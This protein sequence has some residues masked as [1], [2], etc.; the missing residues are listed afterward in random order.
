LVQGFAR[1][2]LLAPFLTS[3]ASEGP[4][5]PEVWWHEEVGGKI[6]KERPPAPGDKDP[7]PNL[8]TVPAKPAPVDAGAWNRMTSALIIDRIAANHAAAMAPIPAPPLAPA[9]MRPVAAQP[10]PASA[11][12]NGASAALTGATPSSAPASPSAAVP[13]PAVKPAASVTA[14]IGPLPPLPT[15]EPPRPAIAPG[16]P[17]PAIPVSAAPPP[18]APR[19]TNELN[20]DFSPN[21]AALTDGALAAIKSL[22]ATHGDRGIA[23]VGYGEAVTSD[24][25]GQAAALDLGLNRAQTLASALIAQGVKSREVRVA[26]EA[27]GRGASLRLLQ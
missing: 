25:L 22:A 26:A 20:V 9:A 17:P 27:A 3:C 23:I 1:F 10:T 6:S 7:F 16:P 11:S 2:L 21:S 15:E 24:P 19:T 5:K 4:T 12:A 18:E 8:S 14:A 13:A